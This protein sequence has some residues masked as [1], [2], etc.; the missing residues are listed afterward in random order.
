MTPMFEQYQR[1]K[2]SAPDSLL[3]FRMGDFYELFYEDAKIASRELELTLTARNKGDPNAIPMAGVPHHA[4]AGYIER[5]IQAGFRVAIAEQVEDPALT[6]TLVRREVVRIITPGVV[7]DT[8]NL[9]QRTPNYLAAISSHAGRFGVAALDCST[10]D[11][12]ATSTA[13]LDEAAAEVSRLEALEL[14]VQPGLDGAPLKRWVKGVRQSPPVEGSF[15]NGT[16]GV[17][18]EAAGRACAAAR[19]YGEAMSGGALPQV[20]PVRLYSTEGFMVVDDTSRRNLELSRTLRTQKR[21]GSLL[22]LLDRT[23]TP[24]GGR[25]L[26]HWLAFP[27]LDLREI[28]S[29]QDAVTIFTEDRGLREQVAEALRPVMDME[30]IA[31]RVRLGTAN[32]RDLASLALALEAAPTLNRVCAGLSALQGQLPD[33]LMHDVRSDIQRWLVDEPPAA[34]SEGG[35]IRNGVHAELDALTELSLNGVAVLSELEQRERAASGIPTL[36]LRSNK[37]FGYYLEVTTAHLHK[38]PDRWIRKQT[39]SNCERFLTQE[40]KE[41]EEQVLSADER[42]KRLELE[43][44]AQLRERV[45]THIERLQRLAGQIASLDVLCS[46]AELAVDQTWCRPVVDDSEDLEIEAGRHPVIEASLD[47]E[48]FVPNDLVMDENQKVI[49][50]TGPNMAGKSTIMRQTALIVLLAQIG[51]FVPARSARLG[52]TDRIFTRVGASDDLGQGQS[53]FMVE[54]AET[55]I[56]LQHATSRS[57]VL[58]DEIGRGT[59]TYD[60]LSIAWAVAEDL[61]DRVKCRTLFATHYHELCDLAE[62]RE[63]VVNLSIAVS[64]HGEEIVFLR[65]LKA[66]GASR[67]YG[68]QCARLAGMPTGVVSRARKLLTNFEKYAP[69]NERQQLSLFG[70]PAAQPANQPAAVE[71]AVDPLR[72]LLAGI[73]PDALSPRDAHAMLYRL[74]ALER[75]HG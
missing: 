19:A 25:L 24:M 51:S 63:N 69:R 65:R 71:P 32:G 49:V 34:L 20:K 61:A 46:L 43:L 75:E 39:L 15:A 38:V 16:P 60:G 2:D 29:R 68:I 70:A 5:L 14:L 73:D 59:S 66:G 27:L 44:F 58:L 42:R 31:S 1:L 47:D 74:V 36:K 53:T 33:D 57:L 28:R 64:E 37:V 72:E 62:I 52:C 50:L 18:D 54:M 41:L 56:I 17:P 30:R 10:G 11:F 9:D 7:Q 12:L 55:A 6:K 35:L 4:A 67:S 8:S 48:R 13:T 23:R 26:R 40:L 22:H 45:G 3:F 21:K